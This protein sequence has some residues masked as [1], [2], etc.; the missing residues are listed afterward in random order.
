VEQLEVQGIP[1]YW[2]AAA[3]WQPSDYGEWTWKLEDATGEVEGKFHF[4]E[5]LGD[6][7]VEEMDEFVPEPG[8]ILLLGSGLAAFAR[9][10]SL[11]RR[12]RE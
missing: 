5:D 12:T 2:A 9:Y 4:A 3:D 10:A 8:S 6:C 1:D 11:R 7:P